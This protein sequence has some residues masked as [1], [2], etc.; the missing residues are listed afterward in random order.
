M[1]K[2]EFS[3]G[4]IIFRKNGKELEVL[5]I[6]DSYGRWSWP[7][8]KIDQNESSHRAAVREIKEEVGLRDVRVLG[9][10]GRTNYF[11]RLKGELI[12]KTVFFFLVEADPGEKLA[13]QKDEI[14]AARWF[15]PDIALKKVEYKGAREMLQKA[16][17]MYKELISKCSG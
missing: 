13:I 2:R 3:A 12:F 16:I 15:K 7:K 1:A 8:G 14:K 10:V 9:K 4:G 5:L 17:R 6:K 11:F